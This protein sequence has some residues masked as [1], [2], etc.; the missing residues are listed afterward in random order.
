M[1]LSRRSIITRR[2][3]D[4]EVEAAVQDEITGT[5]SNVGYRRV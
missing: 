5:G 2:T 3:A 1:G 4:V